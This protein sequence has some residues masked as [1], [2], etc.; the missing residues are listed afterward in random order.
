MMPDSLSCYPF[1]DKDPF[2]L[3]SSTALND[4]KDELENSA[5]NNGGMPHLFF[6]GNQVNKFFE[7]I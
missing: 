1:V 7:I 3:S 5:E 4:H 2:V 6:A